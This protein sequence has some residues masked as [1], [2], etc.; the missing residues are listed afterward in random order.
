M[1][2]RPARPQ[3]LGL[4]LMVAALVLSCTVVSAQPPHVRTVVA[5]HWS[6]ED[7]PSNP[8]VDAAIAAAFRERPDLS[9]DY[10]AEYLE[11]DRFPGDR[12]SLA[13]RDYIGRKY[14]GRRIDLVVAIAEP[15]LQFVLR[16]RDELFPG[17][18]IVYTSNAAA[19]TNAL[20]TQ[21][22]AGVTTIDGYRETVELALRLHP[23]TARLF[24]VAHAPNL[25]YEDVLREE[26]ASIAQRIEVSY[27]NEAVLPRLLA[28]VE[29]VPPGSLILYIRHSR[30][31]PGNR[32][33]PSEVARL[34]AEASAVPVYGIFD[35][36]IGTG[37][38]GGFVRDAK[39]TGTRVGSIALRILDGAR[40][41][42]ISVEPVP[43]RPM[44]DWRQLQRWGIDVSRLPAGADIRFRVPTTW[45]LYWRYIVG[46]LVLTVIQGV[47]IGALVIERARRRQSQTR[48]NLASA[49]GGVGVWDWN[50]ATNEIYVDPFLKHILGYAD[51]EIRNYIDD[52]GRLVHPDDAPMVMAQA[53]QAIEGTRP[54]YEVEHR[55]LHRDGSVRWFLARGSVV[56]KH[57]RAA[58]FAGTDTD[59]TDR[60]TSQQVLEQTQA[61]LTRVSR[62]TALGE[63][64]ATIAH[65]VRQP[66]TAITL[67]A[68]ACLRWLREATPDLAEMRAALEDVVDAG[69]R[70]NELVDRNR[71]LFRQRSVKNEPLDINDVVRDVAALA[72]PRL[73]SNSVVLTASSTPGL[74]LVNGDRIELQQVLL[75]LVGNSIDATEA[76]DAGSRRVEISTVLLTD[77]RVKVSVRDNGVGFENVDMKRLFSFSYTT[78]P[79]GTG[80]GLSLSRSIVE[81]HGGRLWP[82]PNPEGGAI[83]SFTLPVQELAVAAPPTAAPGAVEVA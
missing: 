1:H 5:V 78:K 48:Y 37:L 59:I 67:N 4:G 7:F 21:G 61:E 19:S 38:V 64:A 82:E 10:F 79:S 33:F 45:E 2:R 28:S 46:A 9:V 8:P 58:Q 40:P 34:V 69:E 31:E 35:T 25:S 13:L 12:A 75:N 41:E 65:E 73:Q 6:T 57:G 60:K 22:L 63:F 52:W 14:D 83:F 55:M 53:Q 20:S 71:E 29:A 30:E 49:A 43:L 80:V 36:H 51:H 77:G 39:T 44:F 76:V 11:S 17:A 56:F 32:L 27:I 81:A 66:L 26:L 23:S 3:V 74:P 15:S 70:A 24:V 68:K 72:R 42:D 62:L 18:P 47:I 16:Y 50:L 54:T